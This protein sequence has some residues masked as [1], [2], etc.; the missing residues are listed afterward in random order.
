MCSILGP[1]LLLIY[2]NDLL[3]Y[4]KAYLNKDNFNFIIILLVADPPSPGKLATLKEVLNR[5]KQQIQ[6]LSTMQDELTKRYN[7]FL[8]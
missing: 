2:I 8:I 4:V 3:L 1:F 6:K 7:L 5:Y